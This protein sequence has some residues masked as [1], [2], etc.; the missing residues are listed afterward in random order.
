MKIAA[1]LTAIAA[2]AAISTC[3]YAQAPTM[4]T[5]NTGIQNGT[6]SLGVQ[7]AINALNH[8]DET[9]GNIEGDLDY[10]LSPNLAVGSG[11][12]VDFAPNGTGGTDAT[13]LVSPN[14][15][16]HFT[17]SDPKVVPFVAAGALIPFGVSGLQTTYLGEIGSDFFIKP[18]ESVFV[19][20][21]YDGAVVK[22]GDSD[23]NVDF[24]LKFWLNK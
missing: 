1:L 12:G 16:W 14:V 23:L 7:G 24:G 17:T 10:F 9:N 19:N 13:G 22:H 5:P 2:T 6:I 15:S 8:S 3:A 20:L 4:T 11:L 18:S 21:N